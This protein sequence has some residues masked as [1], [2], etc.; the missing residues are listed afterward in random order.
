MSDSA[1][2]ISLMIHNRLINRLIVPAL[3]PRLSQL[4]TGGKPGAKLVDS[5]SPHTN[6]V[7]ECNMVERGAVRLESLDTIL[8]RCLGH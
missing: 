6:V 3:I 1:P 4:V 5:K 2:I 8:Q 7:Q